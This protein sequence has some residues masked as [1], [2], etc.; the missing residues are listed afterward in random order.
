MQVKFTKIHCANNV[1]ILIDKLQNPLELSQN[2]I[3]FLCAQ[4]TGLGADGVLLFE[5]INAETIFAYQY[6]KNGTS[7]P[8]CDNGAKCIAL[9]A[10]INNVIIESSVVI[11]NSGKDICICKESLPL[12]TTKY[13]DASFL[14]QDVGINCATPILEGLIEVMGGGVRVSAVFANEPYCACFCDNIDYVD[15]YERGAAFQRNKIFQNGINVVFIQTVKHDELRLKVYKK[16]I[17]EV[18][19]CGNAALAAATVFYKKTGYTNPLTIHF[20]GGDVLVEKQGEE[21][22]ITSMAEILFEGVIVKKD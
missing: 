14:P 9:F 5:K 22:L 17:G 4:K 2:T 19:C 20:Y 7:T 15:I 13:A 12:L 3:A 1:F 6:T 21:I 8:L 10:F 16:D 11:K 18:L